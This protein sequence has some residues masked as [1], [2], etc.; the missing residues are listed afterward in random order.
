MCYDFHMPE[1]Q[2]I[3]F[4][5]LESD[6]RDLL[7]TWLAFAQAHVAMVDTLDR[8]L[9]AAHHLPVA[10]FEVLARLSHG[11]GGGLR[12]LE[13]ADQLLLSRSGVTRLMDR[14]EA[15]GLIRREVYP[16]D[17]RGTVALLTDGGRAAFESASPDFLD[18]L[19]ECFGHLS[20]HEAT[21]LRSTLARLAS[22]N[23]ARPSV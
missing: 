2:Q 17:R 23:L 7:E 16:S 9:E 6:D 3:D 11:P 4:S 12:M 21:L 8:R 13:L 10:W 19:R 5:G 20:L 15:A 14:L 18:E 1:H 22:A